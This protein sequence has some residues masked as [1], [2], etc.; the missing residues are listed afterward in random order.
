MR[1]PHL[2]VAIL[3]IAALA[4]SLYAY[5]GSAEEKGDQGTKPEP[6]SRPDPDCDHTNGPPSDRIFRL[7]L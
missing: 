6:V 5:A 3:F 2:S 7:T 4:H 1:T